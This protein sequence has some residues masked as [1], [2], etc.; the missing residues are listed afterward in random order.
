MLP[1]LGT[2]SRSSID[3]GKNRDRAEKY[4]SARPLRGTLESK[5]IRR[6]G[7]TA[8]ISRRTRSQPPHS[9]SIAGRDLT[10]AYLAP[11]H[12]TFTE[13]QRFNIVSMRLLSSRHRIGRNS[14][15]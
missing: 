13:K 14:S 10:S 1:T 8:P 5:V 6:G 9:A 3:D 7:A 15:R 11:S 12:L 4:S 2:R